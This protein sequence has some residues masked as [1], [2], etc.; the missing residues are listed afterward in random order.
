MSRLPTSTSVSISRGSRHTC[1][2]ERDIGSDNRRKSNDW[3]NGGQRWP[4]NSR[5]GALSGPERRRTVEIAR[6]MTHVFNSWDCKQSQKNKAKERGWQIEWKF[7]QLNLKRKQML[8]TK[9]ADRSRAYLAAREWLCSCK[10]F[11]PP[12]TSWSVEPERR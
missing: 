7:D 10:T 5:V 3:E 4:A 11:H 9:Q 12:T 8:R 1:Y 2:N 6:K